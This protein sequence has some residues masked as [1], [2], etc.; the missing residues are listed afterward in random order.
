[1]SL[2]LHE[3]V[4]GSGAG[5]VHAVVTHCRLM[6][7]G[8]VQV[9]YARLS[10]DDM[11]RECERHFRVGWPRNE[12]TGRLGSMQSM[13]RRDRWGRHGHIGVVNTGRLVEPM[14]QDTRHRMGTRLERGSREGGGSGSLDMLIVLGRRLSKGATKSNDRSRGTVVHGDV[15]CPRGLRTA[16]LVGLGVCIGRRSADWVGLRPKGVQDIDVASASPES[17]SLVVDRTTSP[18]LGGRPQSIQWLEKHLERLVRREVDLLQLGD[19]RS[20]VSVAGCAESR[21]GTHS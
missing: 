15:R 12:I 2:L 7:S 19:L 6:N 17:E 10:L 16:D 3:I 14:R 21:K 1:M 20:S 18:A 5:H 13:I 8:R 11:E 9:E 4:L